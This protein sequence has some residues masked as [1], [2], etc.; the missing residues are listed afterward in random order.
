MLK[1]VEKLQN[2]F[3]ELIEKIECN[4]ITKVIAIKKLE[5]LENKATEILN[6]DNSYYYRLINEVTY[7]RDL[8][9]SM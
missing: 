2:N 7:C 9:K 3:F 4:C 8:I 1:Q 6:K 5:I